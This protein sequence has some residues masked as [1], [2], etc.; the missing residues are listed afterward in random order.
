MRQQKQLKTG[1][2][3]FYSLTFISL[4]LLFLATSLGWDVIVMGC[5]VVGRGRRVSQNMGFIH[6]I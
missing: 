4:I 3:L 1:S 5:L 6:W 2:D